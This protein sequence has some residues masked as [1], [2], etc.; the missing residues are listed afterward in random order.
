MLIA[1]DLLVEFTTQLQTELL[2]YVNQVDFDELLFLGLLL[3]PL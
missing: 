1:I 2:T 3:E